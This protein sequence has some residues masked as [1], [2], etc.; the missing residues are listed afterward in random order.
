MQLLPLSCS[1]RFS[2]LSSTSRADVFWPVCAST[3]ANARS[4][5]Q[6]VNVL[7][8]SVACT[9]A[10]LEWARLGGGLASAAVGWVRAAARGRRQARR[11]RG[12]RL[13]GRCAISIYMRLLAY[14]ILLCSVNAPHKR[15]G[16]T[17]E[18]SC[19]S[20]CITASQACAP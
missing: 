2:S 19:G 11:L 8:D 14:A 13:G 17:L 18:L 16:A 3:V 7:C 12:R 6:S 15:G 5:S 10:G 9:V 20:A 4:I 1:A